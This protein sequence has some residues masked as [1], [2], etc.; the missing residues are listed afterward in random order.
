MD[1]LSGTTKL[2]LALT[3][4]SMV[5][6]LYAA[7]FYAPTEREMGHVQRIFYFHMG[8]VW[9]ATVAFIVVFIASIQYLRKESRFSDILAYSSAELGVVFLTITIIT[10][11]IWARHS[12]NTWWT[13]DPQLT[14]T[15]ILWV[16]YVAYLVLRSAIGHDSK[17]ARFAAVF[18]IVAFLDL[19]LVY[20]SARVMRG[21]SPVVFGGRGGGIHPKMMVALV[22]CMASCSFLFLLLLRQRMDLERMQDELSLLT[23]ERLKT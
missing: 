18:A 13:W 19:P 15:F 2:L 21:I 17:K 6:A 9:V 23:T 5:I 11:S 4:L 12:W 14:T 20:V 16:L 22:V 8:S 7:F 1:H 3:F 10:G